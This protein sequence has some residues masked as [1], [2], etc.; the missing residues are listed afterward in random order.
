MDWPT[1]ILLLG[2]L[3]VALMAGIAVVA[4]RNESRKLDLDEARAEEVKRLLARYDELSA[5]TIEAQKRAAADLADL[6]TRLAGI[7]RILRSVE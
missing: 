2:V 1:V 5:A 7:E 6:Q 4:T 3:V